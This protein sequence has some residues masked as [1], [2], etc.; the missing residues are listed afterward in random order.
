MLCGWWHG[1]P[2]RYITHALKVYA[3][4]FILALLGE[5]HERGHGHT[6]KATMT[7]RNAVTLEEL[8]TTTRF[9]TLGQPSVNIPTLA[10]HAIAAHCLEDQTAMSALAI[11]SVRKA[12]LKRL[13]C[14]I[15]RTLLVPI[16]LSHSA[17]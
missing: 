8:Y 9:L 14:V 2:K 3:S 5:W 6:T 13:S 7:A 17:T 15:R 12:G 11:V 1:M 16:T 10:H 4:A